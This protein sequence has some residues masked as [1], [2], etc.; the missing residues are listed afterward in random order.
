LRFGGAYFLLQDIDVPE[1]QQ[2]QMITFEVDDLDGYWGEL[3]VKDLESAFPGVKFRE[4]SEFP[5]GRELPIIDLARVCWHVPRAIRKMPAEPRG[6][7][8]DSD[9][10]ADEDLP[11]V[12][13]RGLSV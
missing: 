10:P 4:P 9:G 8:D 1:W 13:Q 11:E 5:W 12:R 2:N 3:A 6:T 7:S